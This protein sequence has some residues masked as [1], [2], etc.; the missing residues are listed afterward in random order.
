MT[1]SAQNFPAEL[2]TRSPSTTYRQQRVVTGVCRSG[3]S[4]YSLT[5]MTAELRQVCA[6]ER[7]RRKAIG[8]SKGL[9]NVARTD[10]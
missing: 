4:R 3:L 6:L 10:S 7:L 8:I 1:V 2:L 5:E 9:E